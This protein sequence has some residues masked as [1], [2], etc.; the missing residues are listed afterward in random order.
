MNMQPILP[1]GGHVLLD[2]KAYL[3]EHN[4]ASMRDLSA[5]FRLAPEALRSVLSHWMRKGRVV[6]HDFAGGC[7]CSGKSRSACG[8]C[9]VEDS[10]EFYE[11]IDK[12]VSARID[13]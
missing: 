5:H 11:W 6:R 9:G 4:P 7:S 12:E 8:A 13:A 2:V 3:E 10:F 1:N